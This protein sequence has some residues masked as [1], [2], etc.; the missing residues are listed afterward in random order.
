V[1]ASIAK[2]QIAGFGWHGYI[3]ALQILVKELGEDS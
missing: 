3:S 2:G 1:I